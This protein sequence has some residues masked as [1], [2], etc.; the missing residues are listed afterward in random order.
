MGV[1]RADPVYSFKDR[2]QLALSFPDNLPVSMLAPG[3]TQTLTVLTV[4]ASGP[5]EQRRLT[6]MQ[7]L[8]ELQ[9]TLGAG[10]ISLCDLRTID[11]R[12]ASRLD[13]HLEVRSRL[14]LA[15]LGRQE[16]GGLMLPDRLLLLAPSDKHPVLRTAKQIA[17]RA[18][19]A[20]ALPFALVGLEAVLMASICELHARTSD[21]YPRV[22]LLAERRVSSTLFALVGECR[23]IADELST[24]AA[25]LD[26]ALSRAL[27]S[28]A[29]H[30]PAADVKA[31]LE[32]LLAGRGLEPGVAAQ[33]LERILEE[34]LR[35]V[36]AALTILDELN[37]RIRDQETSATL[38]LDRTRNRLMKIEIMATGTAAATGIG[39]CIAGVFGMN[40]E[41]HY[42]FGDTW[43]VTRPGLFEGIASGIAVGVWSLVALVIL[44][45]YGRNIRQC[46]RT[47]LFRARL[48][49]GWWEAQ[50]KEVSGRESGPPAGAPMVD[51]RQGWRRR[52]ESLAS[53]KGSVKGSV[54]RT[55]V[56]PEGREAS[57]SHADGH[58]CLDDE[59]AR[60]A[61]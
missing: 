58:V 37:L 59:H 30:G 46:V 35:H 5:P 55:S 14:M 25:G 20:G 39:S 16:L 18:A 7:L 6:R 43:P 45:L 11:P 28:L 56:D 57:H 54:K 13:P 27:A 10:E 51:L 42:F 31:T 36:R 60:S 4:P 8:E 50:Q 24:Q 21:L 48:P 2:P 40:L 9:A 32:P 34:Y 29:E 3:Q 1:S 22:K 12:Y 52:F 26:G 61:I 19:D 15:S 41:S 38:T 53:V 47:R 23:Q 33:S 17:M 49:R 44:F